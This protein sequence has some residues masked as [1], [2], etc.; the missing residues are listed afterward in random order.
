MWRQLFSRNHWGSISCVAATAVTRS[1]AIESRR[2]GATVTPNGVKSETR[3]PKNHNQ[4]IK[5]AH[6]MSIAL[7]IIFIILALLIGLVIGWVRGGRRFRRLLKGEKERSAQL[8][9]VAVAPEKLKGVEALLRQEQTQRKV[10][11]KVR[12]E[13]AQGKGGG[14]QCSTCHSGI[15]AGHTSGR[16]PERRR[17]I[18]AG[19]RSPC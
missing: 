5:Q 12:C 3:Y 2:Y 14:C 4:K 6:T 1:D 7:S 13:I 15:A 19:S 9:E 16:F 17:V 18:S 11:E 10:L 8:R